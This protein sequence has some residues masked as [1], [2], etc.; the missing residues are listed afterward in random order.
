[1]GDS[2]FACDEVKWLHDGCVGILRDRQDQAIG[3]LRRLALVIVTVAVL[4]TIAMVVSVVG[5][6]MVLSR[7]KLRE[8]VVH[9]MKRGRHQK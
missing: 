1:M 6:D 7:G 9:P 5:R 3:W 8:E 4:C 2:T